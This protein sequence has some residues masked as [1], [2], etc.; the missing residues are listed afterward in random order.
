M[1]ATINSNTPLGRELI[2][3]GISTQQG[4]FDYIRDLPYGRNAD[5]A[6]PALVLSEKQGTCSSKHAL[7]KLV[8]LE[9]GWAEIKLIVGI[10]KMSQ[11]NTPGIGDALTV[12]KLAYI[13]EAHCYLSLHGKRLDL[14]FPGA[15]GFGLEEDLMLEEE[16]QPAQ[17]AVYKVER[18]RAFLKEW[19]AE[20]GL[21]RSLEEVWAIREGC[22]QRLSK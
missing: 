9:Q 19:I 11:A 17:V 6:Q 3:A 8:A 15:G 7:V 12:E 10:Y 20:E 13:P 1:D 21:N 16:I 2:K 14:T 4:L 22:I 18:H 5:R